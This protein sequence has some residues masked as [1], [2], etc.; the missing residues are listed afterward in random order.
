[1]N[2]KAACIVLIVLSVLLL[3]ASCINDKI[4]INITN[5][6]M[7]R[8]FVFGYLEDRNTE[9]SPFVI[10]N[11]VDMLS[12]EL[13]KLGF[14][15]RK[16]ESESIKFLYP[17]ENE[18]TVTSDEMDNMLPSHI[19]D[20]YRVNEKKRK[21]KR[22]SEYLDSN[23]I[24]KV[25]EKYPFNYFVQGA[26]SQINAGELINQK[27]NC[28]I[29]LEIYDNKGKLVSEINF[30]TEGKSLQ[31]SAYLQ[32]TAQEMSLQIAKEMFNMSE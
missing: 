21:R 15:I 5:P 32:K 19:T 16:I 9:F 14:G 30:Y 20:L 25:A 13:S 24:R 27:L 3:T 22:I 12:F 26:I 28:L 1:M 2:R 31:Y 8:V 6:D 10:D 23:E 7:E 17:E 11:F 18:S 4:R 29:F